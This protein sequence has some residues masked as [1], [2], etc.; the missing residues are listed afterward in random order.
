MSPGH[1]R[2][3]GTTNAPQPSHLSTLGSN[4]RGKSGLALMDVLAQKLGLV[5][6][7]PVDLTVEQQAALKEIDIELE[8]LE[9]EREKIRTTIVAGMRVNPNYQPSPVDRARLDMITLRKNQLKSYMVTIIKQE[10]HI[11]YQRTDTKL[12]GVIDRGNQVYKSES[13]QREQIDYDNILGD[14]EE[15]DEEA[16]ADQVEIYERLDGV[17]TRNPL[18]DLEIG[19]SGQTMGSIT[20]AEIEELRRDALSHHESEA[21]DIKSAMPSMAS[22]PVLSGRTPSTATAAASYSPTMTRQPVAMPSSTS[23]FS[24]ATAARSSNPS[25]QTL[26][27]SDEL[28]W[29]Q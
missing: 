22:M 11:K 21:L 14:M 20:D 19:S 2:A 26:N 12:L 16:V 13:K 23:P 4:G 1:G 3:M 6:P 24:Q 9:Q 7:K 27:F 5:K 8:N 25:A 17:A 10:S 18:A 15:I 28:N 29:L